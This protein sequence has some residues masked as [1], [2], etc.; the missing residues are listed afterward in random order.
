MQVIGKGVPLN[1]QRGVAY[2]C[3]VSAL[4][5]DMASQEAH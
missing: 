3:L 1:T 2:F 5:H 4:H